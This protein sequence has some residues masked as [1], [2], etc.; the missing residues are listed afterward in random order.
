M[1][2]TTTAE[3]GISIKWNFKLFSTEGVG[4]HNNNLKHGTSYTVSTGW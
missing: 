4:V 1:H 2:V 3:R